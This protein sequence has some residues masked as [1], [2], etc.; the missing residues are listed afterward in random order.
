[1]LCIITP[2]AT[3]TTDAFNLDALAATIPATKTTIAS[4]D[5]EGNTLTH[6]A[7]ALANKVFA[8]TPNIIGIKTT[9]DIDINI[10][11]PSTWT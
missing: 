5:T 8:I 6:L 9:W 2:K 3:I 11:I 10:P 1:M 7:A 4:P